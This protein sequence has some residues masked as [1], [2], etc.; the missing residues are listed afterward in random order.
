[1]VVFLPEWLANVHVGL[2]AAA[3]DV[4][5]VIAQDIRGSAISMAKTQEAAVGFK[6]AVIQQL[7]Q[8][9]CKRRRVTHEPIRC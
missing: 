3:A 2:V 6:H 7:V 9:G 1:M 8:D 5:V 4:H